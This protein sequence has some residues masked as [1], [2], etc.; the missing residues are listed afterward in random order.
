MRLEDHVY[1]WDNIVIGA[2]L[3]SLLYAINNNYIL[4]FTNPVPPFRFDALDQDIDTTKLG[5]HEDAEVTELEAWEQA[6]LYAGLMGLCPMS[7]RA[8]N[9]RVKEH[10]LVIT[11]KNQ[12]V[13]KANFKKLIVFDDTQLKNLPNIKKQEKERNRVIDWFNVRYGCRHNWE[14]LYGNDDFISSLHFYPTDRSDN[15]TLKDAVAVSYLTDRQ[16]E[17]IDY[18][19]YMARF[20]VE[21]IMKTAGIKGPINGYRDSKPIYRNVKV[22]HA[23]REVVKMVKRYYSSDARYEFRYDSLKQVFKDFQTPHAM[24]KLFRT[25]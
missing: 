4:V 3:R 16:L 12:R 5:F 24:R 21:D 11:T 20:K 23:D 9:I 14:C 25:Q 2:D 7:A 6:F 15:K 8:E 13:V 17:N 1:D 22:E 18:S 19:E 10:T